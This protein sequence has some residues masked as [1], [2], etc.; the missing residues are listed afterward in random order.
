MKSK[1][2]L[3]EE[4]LEVPR[5]NLK[6]KCYV[7]SC[8]DRG[9]ANGDEPSSYCDKKFVTRISRNLYKSNKISTYLCVTTFH[10]NPTDDTTAVKPQFT[11]I[12]IPFSNNKKI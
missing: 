8:Q 2:Y 12:S 6:M 11:V 5:T 1:L 7:W 10:S 3:C 9:S 4:N